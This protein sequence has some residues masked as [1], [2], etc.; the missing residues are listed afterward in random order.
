MKWLFIKVFAGLL[1]LKIIWNNA[2]LLFRSSPKTY[3]QSSGNNQ[4]TELQLKQMELD[5]LR[6]K[7]EI[8]KEKSN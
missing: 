5:I 3:Q 2:H 8:E 7:L 1:M 4:Q 6:L